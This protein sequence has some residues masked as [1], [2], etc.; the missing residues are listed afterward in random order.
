MN[1]N[2]SNWP[3]L[4]RLKTVSNIWETEP[5][6]NDYWYGVLEFKCIHLF[7]T[8]LHFVYNKYIFNFWYIIVNIADQQFLIQ[9]ASCPPKS[10]ISAGPARLHVQD[11]RFSMTTGVPPR[12]V[13]VW[14]LRHL[15]YYI[16]FLSNIIFYRLIL[17]LFT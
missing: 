14:E 11:L 15:R 5:I 4:Y 6:K 17:Q 3:Y 9:I 10:K 12:L 2:K 16:S 8:E 7:N 1:K 13:G